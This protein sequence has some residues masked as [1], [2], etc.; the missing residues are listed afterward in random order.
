MRDI[1]K[2]IVHC[3][4][5]ETGDVNIIRRWHLERGF[6]DV[7]YHF[8]IRR[9]GVIEVGRQMSQIGAHCENHN[10]DS[11]GTCLVGKASFTPAQFESLK[12]LHAQL[13]VLFPALVAYPHNAFNNHKTC[14][15]FNVGEVL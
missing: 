13:L 15:N 10:H 4:D 12:K 1:N 7:G 3:S 8:I 9:D 11:V 6:A 2:H 5:S 14:P